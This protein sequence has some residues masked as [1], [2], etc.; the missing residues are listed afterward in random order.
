MLS[1]AKEIPK[2]PEALWD[3]SSSENTLS[4]EA[5][6]GV[7]KARHA[8]QEFEKKRKEAKKKRGRKD[9]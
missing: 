4:A 3:G 8:A 9:R 6:V 7:A 2:R 5:I 1:R